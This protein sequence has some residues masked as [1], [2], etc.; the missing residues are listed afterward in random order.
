MKAKTIVRMIVAVLGSMLTSSAPAENIQNMRYEQFKE[1]IIAISKQAGELTAASTLL[2]N[3]EFR[4]LSEHADEYQSLA[5]Q[6]LSDKV[7][8]AQKA[9]VVYA[10]EN[11]SFDNYIS[12]VREMLALTT[13]GR[14]D[15]GLLELVLMP[16]FEWNTKLEDNYK[17]QKVVQL[18]RDLRA[19]KVL[20][21]DCFNYLSEI[22]SGEG[23]KEVQ[24]MRSDG[25]IR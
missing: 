14:I 21:Q 16:G 12:F 20:T 19:S 2:S 15:S 17:S 8:T 25:E 11:L 9:M 23:A 1:K 7:P 22:E 24:R 6:F 4:T 5:E 3:A 10:M 18:I 13:K